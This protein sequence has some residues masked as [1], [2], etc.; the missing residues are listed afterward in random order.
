MNIHELTEASA[1]EKAISDY[2]DLGGAKFL[3]RYGFGGS[4]RYYLKQGDRLYDAKAIAGVAYGYQYPE[5][6]ALSRDAFSGGEV[7]SDAANPVLR[8]LG[9]TVLDNQ[10]ATAQEEHDWRLTVWANIQ[11]RRN[12]AGLVTADVLRAVRA[13]GGQQGIWVDSKRT[14]DVYRAGATVALKHTGQH[15]PDDLG[16]EELLY[17]YPVTKRAGHDLAEVNATKAA[18]EL[19]L[20]V[21]AI[22]EV[23]ELRKV[24]LSWVAGWE[25]ES[26]LFLVTLGAE[27]PEEII[28]RDRSEEKPFTLAGNRSHHRQSK[29]KVRPDQSRF[30]I[31][32]FRRYGPRCPLSGISVPEM[33]DATHLRGDAEGGSSDARN[34][35]P[36]NAALHRAFDAHLF[37]INP[38]TLTV[39]VR[40]DGPTLEQLGIVHPQLDLPRPPHREALA[41]RYAEW[42]KRINAR[43]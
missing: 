6:G 20:P 36:M 17:H 3:D 15:Y 21:F 2:D 25:D 29:R 35:L 11:S 18:A 41:W 23:G 14:K 1:V 38:D 42:T 19:K 27:E 26:K 12:D 9:F 34:G 8:G 4:T 10:T 22:I 7:A 43:K 40:P 37:A 31:E 32:V 33:I 39:E 16:E 5:R 13:Y 24:H 28:D 30:K